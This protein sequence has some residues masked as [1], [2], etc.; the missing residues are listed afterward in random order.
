M[1]MAGSGGG[2]MTMAG[3]GSDKMAEPPRPASVTDA[4][5]ATAEK[6]VSQMEKLGG[7]LEAANGDCKKATASISAAAPGISASI[8]EM[9]KMKP[10]SDPAAKEWFKAK[11]SARADVMGNAMMKLMGTCQADKDFA[12]AVQKLGMIKK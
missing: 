9:E 2:S 5:I 4:M 7:E 12:A 11:Y 10:D 6:A 8:A 1:D 3:S